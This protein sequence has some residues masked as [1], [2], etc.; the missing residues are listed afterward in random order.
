MQL[1]WQA[2]IALLASGVV[3]LTVGYLALGRSQVPPEQAPS[4]IALPPPPPAAPAP[5]PVEAAQADP[6]VKAKAPAATRAVR[7]PQTQAPTV[8]VPGGVAPGAL[9]DD[10]F[11][12]ARASLDAAAATTDTSMLTTG[13]GRFVF[14]ELQAA[15]ITSLTMREGQLARNG[16]A[17][18]G[19]FAQN[20]KVGTVK[21]ARPRVELL[22]VGW[23]REARPV[24]AHIRTT[25]SPPI[26]GIVALKIG[27][28]FVAVTPDKSA[29]AVLPQ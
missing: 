11:V 17:T 6:S 28:V 9:G 23:D 29:P 1:K 20:A 8:A 25:G 27:E 26:E 15:A 10:P 7:A 22:H 5:P 19:K 18:Y 21:G 13:P 14:L 2:L 12:P 4:A 16:A 3:G 24:V